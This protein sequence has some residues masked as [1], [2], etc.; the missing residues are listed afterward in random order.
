[1]LAAAGATM[2]EVRLS[3]VPAVAA[4][5]AV[6]ACGYDFDQFTPVSPDAHGD[7]SSLPDGDTGAAEASPGDAPGAPSDDG[8]DAMT[9]P[10]TG[11]PD[12]TT[13]AGAPPDAAREG[14]PADAGTDGDAGALDAASLASGLVAYYLFD[15][16]S[17]TSAADSSGN[18]HTATLVGGA[19]FA[20]GLRNNAVSLSGSS[21]YVS[22]PSGTVTGLS[23]FSICTWVRLGAATQWSRVFDF[24]TGTNV[25]MFLT[26]DSNANTE[27]FSIT[28][29]GSAQEQQL[30][31]PALVAGS[32]L[33]V[34]V[35]LTAG[36]DTLYVNGAQVAQSTTVT[37]TPTSLGTTTQNWLGRSEFTGDPYLT[38]KL[39]NFRI[40]NRALSAAEVQVLYA[41]NL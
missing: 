10:D 18:G 12:A 16:A 41:G 35:T 7:G 28:T 25:Y 23:S 15:E 39:D 21:Q 36:T 40:Y 9:G 8:P 17:G 37:L 24:G 33:H 31:A 1:M 11:G 19:T 27:R 38:G 3:L 4:S 5:L 29:G 22:L 30:N 34:A 14:G 26:V 6:A 2:L 20:G 32:W 13:E